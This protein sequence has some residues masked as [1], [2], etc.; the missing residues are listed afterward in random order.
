[1]RSRSPLPLLLGVIALWT[2]AIFLLAVFDEPVWRWLLAILLTLGA[3]A[4]AG[5]WW[6]LIAPAVW[7]LVVL[8][9]GAVADPSQS[10]WLG[11]WDYDDRELYL[12][13]TLFGLLIALVGVGGFFVGLIA[14]GVV[15]GKALR[16]SAP[17]AYPVPPYAAPPQQYQPPPPGYQPPPYQPPQQ[18]YQPPPPPPPPG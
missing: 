7:V 18:P 10:D 5:S 16:P 8:L 9:F 2:L 11:Y 4:A 13:T 6:A 1:M 12:E 14:I 15:V 17:Q 3:G